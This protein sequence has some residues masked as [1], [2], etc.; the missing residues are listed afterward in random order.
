MSQLGWR[1]QTERFGSVGPCFG[2]SSSIT[3]RHTG[4]NGNGYDTANVSLFGPTATTRSSLL[5]R[6]GPRGDFAARISDRKHFAVRAPGQFRYAA[7]VAAEFRQ[8]IGLF[9]VHRVERDD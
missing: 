3:V 2:S 6:C 9:G 5:F 7:G 8:R 1:Y 4:P